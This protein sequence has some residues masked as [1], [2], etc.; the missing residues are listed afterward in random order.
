MCGWQGYPSFTRFSMGGGL[1]QPYCIWMGGD[2][3]QHVQL[4]LPT[5]MGTNE[6]A[7][8]YTG[9]PELICRS[10]PKAM[11]H[12]E[13]FSLL[14]FIPSLTYAEQVDQGDR[15]ATFRGEEATSLNR[16]IAESREF[17][18]WSDGG[19]APKSYSEVTGEED[20][21]KKH[22]RWAED[23]MRR[24]TNSSHR[25]RAARKRNVAVWQDEY[26]LVHSADPLL[27]AQLLCESP[28][29]IGPDWANAF[30]RK[31]CDME[32]S[33]VLPFCESSA[34]ADCF[35][36]EAEE[37]RAPRVRG[38]LAVMPRRKLAYKLDYGHR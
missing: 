35:D 24:P 18:R 7:S 19:E 26:S 25:R 23:N 21:I 6:T 4:H 5:F 17:W 11:G 27:S 30:E 36:V 16:T 8:S 13:K 20:V 9:D 38:S 15:N 33:R 29:V 3:P 34:D 1:H 28:S 2:H 22:Y 10:P 12:S 31:Y 32:T 37:I 14:L